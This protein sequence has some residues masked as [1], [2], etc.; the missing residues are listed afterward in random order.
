MAVCPG[1][2]R[3]A[4]LP[5]WIGPSRGDSVEGG[6]TLFF[7]PPVPHFWKPGVS[8]LSASHMASQTLAPMDDVLAPWRMHSPV[9]FALG[10]QKTGTTLA[11]AALS[12]AMN[13]RYSPEAAMDCCVAN[14]WQDCA[15]NHGDYERQYNFLGH[16]MF[17]SDLRAVEQRGENIHRFFEKCKEH[18]LLGPEVQVKVDGSEE[19]EMKRFPITVLKADEFMPDSLSLANFARA[20]RLNMRL[21]FV[22]RHPLSVVR[23][24]QSWIA[25]RQ[26]QGKHAKLHPGV[27]E[28]SAMWRKS[29]RTYYDTEKCTS[30]SANPGALTGHPQNGPNGPPECVFAAV[31]RFEDLMDAPHDTVTAVYSTL[32]PRNG[33]HFPGAAAQGRP[34][35]DSPLPDGWRDRVTWAMS[36]RGNHIDS[37]VRHASVNESFTD[38]DIKAVHLDG[39]RELMAHF[40][41]TM[42]D[43]WAEPAE[44][45]DYATF[46]PQASPEPVLGAMPSPSPFI[47][48]GYYNGYAKAMSSPSPRPSAQ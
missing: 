7:S 31:I 41:Y 2:G 5:E 30:E 21:I 9:V 45:A 35:R 28:I 14:G 38:E 47:Y 48:N 42:A 22:T 37:F 44:W 23:A 8:P 32:F 43:V 36:Q 1:R 20:E 18:T 3:I 12:A 13:V 15:R 40:N 24:T 10:L 33:G 29:A 17:F 11:G 26:L 27:A 16:G 39:G 34:I 25:E 19:T 4:P 46:E 6:S